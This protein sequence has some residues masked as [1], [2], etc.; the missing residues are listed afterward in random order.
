MATDGMDTSGNETAPV[1]AQPPPQ[2]DPQAVAQAVA[3]AI[4][5]ANQFVDSYM[6][7]PQVPRGFPHQQQPVTSPNGQE[8]PGTDQLLDDL[9]TPMQEAPPLTG[10][11]EEP[12]KSGVVAYEQHARTQRQRDT[13][14][15]RYG[16]DPETGVGAFDDAIDWLKTLGPNTQSALAELQRR[17]SYAQWQH[18]VAQGNADGQLPPPPPMGDPA[19][20]GM[21]TAQPQGDPAMAALAAEVRAS[22]DLTRQMLQQ[23]QQSTVKDAVV[24]ALDRYNLTNNEAAIRYVGMA[25][26]AN[27]ARPVDQIV[28]E[29][30]TASGLAA[31]QPAPYGAPQPQASP[32]VPPHQAAAARQ[33]AAQLSPDIARGGGS[34]PDPVAQLD[35]SQLAGSNRAATA[36][37]LLEGAM[38]QDAAQGFLGNQ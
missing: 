24:Q 21:P 8:S 9:L 7:A 6:P 15:E 4:Q 12:P 2:F 5:G 37:H 19:P 20:M 17:Q 33:A 16:V 29:F 23:G 18:Q 35:L 27:D 11:G 34:S 3:P 25:L 26:R 30:A 14:R 13:M 22:N 32:P 36:T 38:A 31:P 10:G 28:G 1:D